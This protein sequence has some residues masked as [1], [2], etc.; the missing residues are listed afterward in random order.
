MASFYSLNG[1]WLNGTVGTVKPS[2]QEFRIPAGETFDVDMA[3]VD[4]AG[5]A[6][7]LTDH[8]STMYIKR[9]L[10]D[11][12]ILTVS[13]VVNVDPTTGLV[14]FSFDGTDTATFSGLYYYDVWIAKALD[15]NRIVPP[16]AVVF[17]LS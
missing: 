11:P 2:V 6:V 5:V 7:D 12:A 16:S 15:T 9:T 10:G 13:G 8:T 3:V 17:D 1:V 4:P 14:T